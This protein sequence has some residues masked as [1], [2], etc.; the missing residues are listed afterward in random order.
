LTERTTGGVI[1]GLGRRREGLHGRRGQVAQRLRLVR[2]LVLV[3]LVTCCVIF[4]Q[5]CFGTYGCRN[6]IGPVTEVGTGFATGVSHPWGVG[7]EVRARVS[8]DL[9]NA[10]GALGSEVQARVGTNGTLG[11]HARISRYRVVLV[12]ESLYDRG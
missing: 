10:T 5:A 1:E 7:P 8:T 9:L 4:A 2:I 11:V 3:G 12:L 6:A